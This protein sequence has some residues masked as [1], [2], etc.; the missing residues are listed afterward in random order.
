MVPEEEGE[1]EGEGEDA[2]EGSSWG[3][4]DGAPRDAAREVIVA[5]RGGW[6]ARVNEGDEMGSWRCVAAGSGI[7][8]IFFYGGSELRAGW[9]GDG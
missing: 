2:R 7:S 8:S 3:C 4:E 6:E 5:L 9:L 1:E